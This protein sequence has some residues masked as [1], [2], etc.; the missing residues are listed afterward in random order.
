[1][2]EVAEEQKKISAWRALGIGT[3]SLGIQS[4]DAAALKLLGRR[5]SPE[6]ARR[7]VETALAAGADGLLLDNMP[8]A[9]LRE[10]VAL[11]DG[12][13]PLEASGGINL[14]TIRAV[15][16]TGVDYISTSRITMGSEAVAIGLDYAL[17]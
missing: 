5:H 6:Q 3:L 15:A 9:V 2:A 1:M 8:P 7:S 14:D 13:V 11:V 12:R 10:A 16:E 17:Q 4:F